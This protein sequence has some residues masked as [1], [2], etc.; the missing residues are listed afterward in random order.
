M[1]SFDHT[2]TDYVVARAAFDENASTSF[3]CS[4]Q[5]SGEDVTYFDKIPLGSGDSVVTLKT[6]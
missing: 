3:M 5:V 6:S 4:H 2:Y 1:I